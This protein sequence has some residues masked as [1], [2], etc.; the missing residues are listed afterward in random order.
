MQA[1]QLYAGP[2]ALQHLRERGLKPRDVRVVAG[3]AGGPKGL[4]LSHLDRQVFGSFLAGTAHGVHLVGASI[5]AWRMATGALPE[6]GRHFERLAREY[7]HERYDPEP[8]RKTPSAEQVSRRFAEQLDDFFSGHVASLIA[9]PRYRL[10]IVTSRGRHVL[11]REGRWRTPLGY[12]GAVISN[13]ASRKALSAWLER[14]VF[15]SPGEALPVNLSDL[16]HRTVPLS[17][18]NF[19]PAL[20]ASCSIPFVLKAV[21][22]IPGGPP[23]AYWDGGI[24]DYHLHWNY[25]SIL[26][27]AQAQA[28]EEGGGLVL[29]PHFQ[30]SLV[31]GWL[32]KAW[33]S[34]HRATA[35][36]DNVIVLAPKGPWV[37]SLPN[38]KLPDRNDFARYGRDHDGRVRDW[39]RALGES[40][41]LADEWN[42]WLARGAP[43]DEVLAL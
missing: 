4:I 13:A 3:A 27:A 39:T 33:R 42:E 29:Y 28:E 8:G 17:E 25:S 6:P 36:L 41:R 40:E 34:R 18:A 14:V 26:D 30:Q 10:H 43:V 2:R 21:H 22:D 19:Q 38:G 1:L 5:G 9:H 32:D 31:P 15:S 16:R 23:G 35:Y 37:Q 11:G 7:I 20:L 24:T 12:L